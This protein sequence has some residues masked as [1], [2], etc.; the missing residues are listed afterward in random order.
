M[1]FYFIFSVA[2]IFCTWYTLQRVFKSSFQ[3]VLEASL[4]EAQ[5]QSFLDVFKV[6]RQ[7]TQI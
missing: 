1:L 7:E 5:I 6:A 4:Q 3:Y 2:E